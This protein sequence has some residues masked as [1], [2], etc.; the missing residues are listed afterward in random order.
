MLVHHLLHEVKECINIHVGTILVLVELVEL[1][2]HP[3]VTFR[4]HCN[5]CFSKCKDMNFFYSGGKIC[6]W[7]WIRGKDC[8]HKAR[9]PL[10]GLYQN[11]TGSPLSGLC[12]IFQSSYLQASLHRRAEKQS[13]L[14]MHPACLILVAGEGFEPTTSGLWARRATTA[15]PRT[16]FIS[17]WFLR[18]I[19]SCQWRNRMQ[20]YIFSFKWPNF[21]SLF[22][23]IVWLS[24]FWMLRRGCLRR[25]NRY[26]SEGFWGRF[27]CWGS[28]YHSLLS[29]NVPGDQIVAPSRCRYA[30]ISAR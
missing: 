16:L 23:A 18:F 22:L 15:L 10:G 27:Q 8:G 26:L 19:A 21:S 4:N 29:R 3:S 12:F 17:L 11:Q 25:G 30:T 13:R 2:E 20:K 14:L 5:D 7:R 24:V 6:R 9:D 1:V 28:L